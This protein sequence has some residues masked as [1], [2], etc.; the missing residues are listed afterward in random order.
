MRRLKIANVIRKADRREV[1]CN[2]NGV[3]R[4]AAKKRAHSSFLSGSTESAKC[5]TSNGERIPASPVA[6]SARAT[7]ESER[8]CSCRITGRN[9]R[10]AP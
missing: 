2:Q 3:R 9:G 7:S 5:A 1:T 8:P 10:S 4:A 6:E